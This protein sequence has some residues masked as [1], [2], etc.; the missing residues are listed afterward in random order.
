MKSYKDIIIN[1]PK[2]FPEIES[3]SL[4]KNN[5]IPRYKS[6]DSNLPAGNY[7]ILVVD[8]NACN[9]S[10][11]FTIT[12]PSALTGSLV[13]STDVSCF[14]NNDGEIIVQ[15]STGSGVAPYSYSIDGIN[16]GSSGTFSNLIAN[17]YNVIIRDSRYYG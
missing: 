1:N 7:G 4:R 6:L 16:F 8:V 12:E 15:A 11:A 17:N 13:S 9:D 3:L 10:I 2:D 14:G 5:T